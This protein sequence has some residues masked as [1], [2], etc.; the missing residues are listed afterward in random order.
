MKALFALHYASGRSER[1]ESKARVSGHRN[2]FA[3]HEDGL[4]GTR[5]AAIGPRSSP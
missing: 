1:V 5:N 2:A 4:N 3:V